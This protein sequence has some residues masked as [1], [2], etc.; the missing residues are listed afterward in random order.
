MM[1]W[2]ENCIA[3]LDEAKMFENSEHRTRFIE[4]MD[5]YSEYPFFTKGLCKCM[6]LSAWDDEHF[7][8]LLETLMRM[9]LGKEQDT[10]DMAIHGEALAEEENGDEQKMYCLSCEFLEG[11][12]CTIDLDTVSANTAYIMKQALK[13]A[14]II[15]K[16]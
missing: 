2:K 15:E 10:E 11:K 9:A 16:L 5:C 14:E 1:G 3:V 13:A 12:P 6:Y 4:L 7:A 8:I